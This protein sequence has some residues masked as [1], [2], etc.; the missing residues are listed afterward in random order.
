MLVNT[1][2]AG[3]L[4]A[5]W[6]QKVGRYGLSSTTRKSSITRKK[7]KS[8]RLLLLTYCIGTSIIGSIIRHVVLQP[9]SC[10]PPYLSRAL[11]AFSFVSREELLTALIPVPT[12]VAFGSSANLFIRAIGS[13]IFPLSS[14]RFRVAFR[15][16][17]PL[18]YMINAC[19]FSPR[20]YLFCSFPVCTLCLRV[21]PPSFPRSFGESVPE[22][23][24][25]IAL[26]KQ[27]VVFSLF[28]RVHASSSS[29]SSFSPSFGVLQRLPPRRAVPRRRSIS[30][31]MRPRRYHRFVASFDDFDVSAKRDERTREDTTTTTT[32]L[33]V[34]I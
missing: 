14:A 2:D 6:A 19:F 24:S 22:P 13:S 29:F 26:A 32:T 7:K 21:S 10:F 11:R 8:A 15:F 25:P 17:S 1:L 20:L 5:N 27:S 33:T 16:F 23:P 31:S 30:T 18:F 28:S 34:P 12:S 4:D 3:K 9:P